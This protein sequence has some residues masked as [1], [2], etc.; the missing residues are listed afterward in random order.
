MYNRVL[1]PVRPYSKTKTM[2]AHITGFTSAFN[3]ASTSLITRHAIKNH[4]YRSYNAQYFNMGTPLAASCITTSNRQ[5]SLYRTRQ[6][7]QLAQLAGFNKY[8]ATAS[9]A[10]TYPSGYMLPPG[11]PDMTV[12]DID[13]RLQLGETF[14]KPDSSETAAIRIDKCELASNDPTEDRHV[15]LELQNGSILLGIFDGHADTQCAEQLTELLPV[16]LQKHLATSQDVP[17]ALTDAFVAV[18]DHLLNLPF[19]ALDGFDSMTIEQIAALPSTERIKIRDMILPAL[20]GSCAVMGYI[21]KEDVYV[22]HAGD[23]RVVLGSMSNSGSW[24]AST[25]T[26]DHQVGN[27]NEM[28]TLK[29]EHPDELETVAFRHCLDGPLRVI[30]GLV[31][32]RA[33]GDARYKWPMAVQHKISALMKGLPSRRRQ[34]PML[35]YCLTP[36]YVHARPDISHVTLTPQDCFLVIASDGLFE[37][38]SNEHVVNIVGDFLNSS[39]NKTNSALYEIR[40][41]NVATHLLRQALKSG[42]YD[43]RHVSRLLTLRPSECRNWRDDILIQVVFLKPALKFLNST[44]TLNTLPKLKE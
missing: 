2:L 28:A 3:H 33:F 9:E 39:Q 22:A 25:L 19:Q 20:S 34:W 32:T 26:N 12:E 4:L 11:I 36:P 23:S 43:D 44:L 41:E 42:K 13:L 8:V 30:G 29:K 38:L 18:D 27:P 6:S 24:V 15:S 5:L 37:E 10:Q 7:D 40:H 1:I 35:R 31:P 14:F 16:A 21:G 17:R